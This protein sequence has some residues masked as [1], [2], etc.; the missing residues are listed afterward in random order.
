MTACLKICT[1]FGNEFEVTYNAT[2]SKFIVLGSKRPVRYSCKVTLDGQELKQVDSIDFL[3]NTIRTDM[4]EK[5]DVKEK[6]EDLFGRVNTVKYKLSGASYS[7]KSKIFTVKCA[8][9]YGS[10]TWN[11]TDKA[12]NGYW[13]AYGQSA[14][15]LLGLPPSCP[16]VTVDS[17]V[18]AKAAPHVMYKKFMNLMDSMKTSVN[19]RIRFIFEN[20]MADARSYIRRNIAQVTESW[21][22]MQP[23]LFSPDNSQRTIDIKTLLDARE[24][25]QQI[26]LTRD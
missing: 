5:S 19:S 4:S 12:V 21:G 17:I 2:K 20:S 16:T 11:L 9:S 15:R 14:R 13:S 24:G 26:G 3:G 8:H 1:E 7:V 6:V 22:G 23:P 25:R 10:E 18:G